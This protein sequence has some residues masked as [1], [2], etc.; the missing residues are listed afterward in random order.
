[1]DIKRIL[2]IFII[3]FLLFSGKIF[4]V[5][6]DQG[7]ISQYKEIENY[8]NKILDFHEETLKKIIANLP[9]DKRDW[10]APLYEDYQVIVESC[11]EPFA[12][13]DLA[14]K[15][16]QKYIHISKG[17]LWA[18]IMLRERIINWELKSEAELAG[19][20]AHELGH[21]VLVQGRKIIISDEEYVKQ[22][23]TVDAFAASLLLK[24][25]YQPL[26]VVNTLEKYLE[27]CYDYFE[28]FVSKY[29]FQKRIQLVKKMV[30]EAMAKFPSNEYKKFIIAT[31]EEFE[32][33]KELIRAENTSLFTP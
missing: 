28:H 15:S 25:R 17:Y 1:M 33:I 16:S 18:R 2:V 6:V 21:L 12:F 13:V 20:L 9:K 5:D 10:Y 26:V 29:V 3:A 22:E 27:N 7:N 11:D 14:T 32:K 8:L 24:E 30:L 23:V 19:I 4:A 31:Q